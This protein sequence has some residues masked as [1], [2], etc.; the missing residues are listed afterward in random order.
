MARTLIYTP[1]PTYHYPV[2]WDG[3]ETIFK[4]LYEAMIYSDNIAAAGET[5][6]GVYSEEATDGE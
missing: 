2:V 4:S 5:G 1:D 6:V 3:G